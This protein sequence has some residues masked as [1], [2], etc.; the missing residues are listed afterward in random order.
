MEHETIAAIATPMG[1]GG[2]GIIKI[3]GRNA[4]S[5]ATALFRT[6]NRTFQSSTI[7]SGNISFQRI[8]Y[9]FIHDPNTNRHIDE[10]LLSLMPGPKSYTREDIAEINTHGGFAVVTA[11]LDLVL[12]HGAR[13]AEPGEFTK[14]AFINGRIDLTQAEAVMDVINAK[15]KKALELSA[16]QMNGQL[17]D[18]IMSI[19]NYIH[20]VNAEIEAG[21]DFPEEVVL[22]RSCEDLV[23][24]LKQKCIDH[25]EALLETYQRTNI[26][27]TGIKAVI[28]GKPNVGKSSLMNCL[29]KRDRVIVSPFPGT[30]RDFVEEHIMID[31]IPVIFADTAGLHSS[32]DPIELTGIDKTYD[33]LESADIILFVVDISRPLDSDDYE[34]HGKVKDRKTLLVLNKSDLPPYPKDPDGL[35]SDITRR[36]FAC[37]LQ[38]VGIKEIETSIKEMAFGNNG[39]PENDETFSPNLRH[40][41]LIEKSLCHL[42][43]ACEGLIQARPL[44]VIC[45][46]LKDA[47]KSLEE[48]IG[49]KIEGTVLDRIF[50]RFCIGK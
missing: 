34:I 46:D 47:V 22:Q 5:I 27:K 14:R 49:I 4:F 6:K 48:I 12:Q 13:M 37:A 25:L 23:D 40:K 50:D 32:T 41:N 36:K 7:N 1:T 30:T 11:V 45:I 15:S 17:K 8:F 43:D 39:F 29:V 16:L 26:F 33:Y 18:E 31:D 21:I 20:D 44:E 2:I 42:M 10:V 35:F 38:C 19:L 24:H 28:V 3:S 9:G